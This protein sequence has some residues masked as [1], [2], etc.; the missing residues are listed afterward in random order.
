MTLADKRVAFVQFGDY[1][2]AVLR[3][4]SGGEETYYAQRYSV[5]TVSAMAKGVDRVT[6]ICV[7]AEEYNEPLPNGVHG[8]GLASVPHEPGGEAELLRAVEHTNPTDVI[9]SSPFEGV[10]RWAISKA[11]GRVFPLLADSFLPSLRRVIRYKRLARLLND[12][13]IAIVGNHNMNASA[14]L[15]RIGVRAE[16]VLP[17]DWPL[18]HRPDDVAVKTCPPNDATK[19]VIYV[20]ALSEKK[21]VGDVISAVGRLAGDGMDVRL[22]I[23]GTGER[24]HFEAMAKE[25]GLAD[26]VAF[27]GRIAHDR[28]VELMGGADAVVVPSRHEYPEGLPMT[29][30]DALASRTPLVLSDHPMFAGKIV[31]GEH[32]LEFPAGDVGA[33]AQVLRRLFADAALYERLSAGAVAGLARIECPAKWG[34]VVTRWVRDEPEDQ[35]WLKSH[36]LAATA[37]V[38]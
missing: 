19:R 18:S 12:E 27:T 7:G 9:V 2:E 22:T 31:D 21:G 24:E 11:G 6:V 15:V 32:G 25:H 16:K 20:G 30:Y 35:H 29:I 36:T 38:S 13:R 17:W 3:F 23:V 28:V 4:A 5:E 33:L 8:V 34:D 26:R 14:S 1:R 37:E 10:I